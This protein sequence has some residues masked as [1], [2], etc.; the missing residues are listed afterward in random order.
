[1]GRLEKHMSR[2][3]DEHHHP[4]N[5]FLHSAGIPMIFAGIIL[6]AW[7]RWVAGAALFVAGWALLFLGHRIEGNKPA[8]LQGGPVYFLVGPLWVAR[9]I[10]GLFAKSPPGS[11]AKG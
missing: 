4:W 11:A 8:F 3:D 6:A 7:T 9:E 5:K 1:M 2:Y 10:K